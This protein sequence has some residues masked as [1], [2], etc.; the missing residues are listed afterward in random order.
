MFSLD[1]MARELTADHPLFHYA[2]MGTFQRIA[3]SM[4]KKSMGN[5]AGKKRKRGENKRHDQDA[6]QCAMLATMMM[7]SCAG[8]VDSYQD[9]VW[10]ENF[11]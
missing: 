5:Q 4:E 8:I 6:A 2:M 9:F 7:A 10:A 1:P 11:V 3:K